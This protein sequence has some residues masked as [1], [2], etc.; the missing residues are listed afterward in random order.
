MFLFEF[1]NRISFFSVLTWSFYFVAVLCA[2]IVTSYVSA[3]TRKYRKNLIAVGV[4][5]FILG[6]LSW[7]SS[8]FLSK[9]NPTQ[10]L[11][12]PIE[13]LGTTQWEEP[14]SNPEVDLPA[15]EINWTKDLPY[16]FKFKLK[17]ATNFKQAIAAEGSEIAYLDDSGNVRGFNAYT[18]LNHWNIQLH[19]KRVLDQLEA[20][21]KLYLLDDT[22][23]SL[24]VSCFDLVNPSL[25][26]QRTI[27]NSKDGALAF[28][29]DSQSL[30]ITAGNGGIWSLKAKTGE[31]LWKRPELF[32]KLKAIVSPKHLAVFEPV[33]ANKTG[34]WYFLDLLTGK[35]LQKSPHVYS[36]I[37]RFFVDQSAQASS[38]FLG[39]VDLENFFYMNAVDLS[40]I[41]NLRTPTPV[42]ILRGVDKDRLIFLYE[43]GLVELRQRS[44]S[45][46][47]YQKQLTGV[48]PHWLRLS[49]DL[50]LLAIPSASEDG[51]QGISFFN[52]ASGD[53]LATGRLT[54]PL[55]DLIFFGDWVYLFSENYVWAFK[56]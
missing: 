23:L 21:R 11:L 33:I 13:S 32:S 2:L 52:L 43:S 8:F 4:S 35:T 26:W 5:S 3:T 28:D 29:S 20:Q 15:D 1:L 7:S 51:S 12:T 37:R 38:S 50:T 44:D 45:S 34:S 27:P 41:W 16:R 22:R 25:L 54:E 18:G 49:S 14:V 47:I 48:K 24:R 36:D 31:I 17:F 9:L 46:L 53:Y 42:E 10:S 56:K 19:A 55:L 40:Q 39:E 30:V 6:T